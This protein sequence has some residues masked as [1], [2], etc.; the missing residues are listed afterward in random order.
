MTDERNARVLNVCRVGETI[1]AKTVTEG[2]WR[3]RAEKAAAL[4]GPTRGESAGRGGSDTSTTERNAAE[5]YR[6]GLLIEDLRDAVEGFE[7]AHRHL[8][9]LADEAV[10]TRAFGAQPEE[11][12]IEPVCRDF[13][14][15]KAGA[16]EWGDA[17]C[18]VGSV[19]AG[20]CSRHY[21]AWY[22]F[23]KA[24]GIDTGKDFAA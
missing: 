2:V 7:I 9:R 20:L 4:D 6:L 21:M 19:K 5:A 15:G 11:Q 16:I 24:R 3:L 22:R 10:R 12:P 18:C 8:A 1:T 14:H 13:Q 17:T 23:R